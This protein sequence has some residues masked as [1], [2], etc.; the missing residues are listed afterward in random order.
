MLTCFACNETFISERTE[1]RGTKDECNGEA[2]HVF[3]VRRIK[4][5]N[6]PQHID[7]NMTVSH[8]CLN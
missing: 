5:L 3:E 6:R 8:S 7:C 1:G 4:G 2:F